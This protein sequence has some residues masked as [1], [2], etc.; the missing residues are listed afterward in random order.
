MPSASRTSYRWQ[1]CLIP[2]DDLLFYQSSRELRSTNSTRLLMTSPLQVTVLF[3]ISLLK[4]NIPQNRWDLFEKYYTLLRDREAQKPG[5][6]ATIIRNHK[7]Q[8]DDL[9]YQ[10]G[11]LLHVMA[12]VSGG[13]N[14]YLTGDQLRAL[15]EQLLRVEEFSEE[16]IVGIS[17]DLVRI[18]TDR[19]VLTQFKS[20]RANSVRCSVTSGIHGRCS[21]YGGIRSAVK[22]KA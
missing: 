20:D 8:I 19:L 6:T 12:E 5:D 14:P 13:A 10:A 21:N 16:T 7:R 1:D 15:I 2:S 18:A 11:L 3:G 4:G 9:H 22:C 17:E